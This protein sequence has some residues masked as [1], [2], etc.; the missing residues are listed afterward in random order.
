[1]NVNLKILALTLTALLNGCIMTSSSE[2]SIKK[3]MELEK[4]P[5]QVT[6]LS[7]TPYLADM[8][9]ALSEYGFEVMPMPTQQQ[10]IEIRNDSQLSKYNEAS[11]R[12]GLTLSTMNSGMTCAITDFNIHHFTLMLTDIENNRV[13]MV[14]KQKGA[15]GPCSSVEPVFESLSAALAENW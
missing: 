4:G 13:I 2:V 6:F 11:T 15:D 1:M 3:T 12:W 10:I 9:I 8:S 7:N 5:M 14:L